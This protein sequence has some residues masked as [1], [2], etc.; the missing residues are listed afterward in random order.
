[1]ITYQSYKAL[2]KIKNNKKPK[3]KKDFNSID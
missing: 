3:P 1:M 2:K